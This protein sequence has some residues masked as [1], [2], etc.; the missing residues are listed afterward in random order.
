M[1]ALPGVLHYSSSSNHQV[2]ASTFTIACKKCSRLANYLAQSKVKYPDYYCQPV[3]AFGDPDAQLL[4]VGL[5]PG[6]HGANATARP[7]T[8]DHAG[9]I[10][11][12]TLHKYGF[13]NQAESHALDDGLQLRN[14]RITNAVKCVPPQNKPTPAEA[15]TCGLYLQEEIS[16]LVGRHVIL[17]LGRI[18][19]ESILRALGLRL[20]D[21]TFAHA[22]Q[23][24]LNEQLTLV[25]SYHCSRYNTQTKRLTEPQFEAVFATIR[26]LIDS[27]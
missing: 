6:L 20:K 22:A 14:A 2:T 26:T 11:Y 15:R 16:A 25:D 21:Y 12:R 10:L 1:E 3:P 17:A 7:F 9:I 23:H 18:A 19:H 24:S 13:A 8:G 4:I 27:M 5:A